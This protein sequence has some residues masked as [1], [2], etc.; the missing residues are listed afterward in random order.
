MIHKTNKFLIFFLCVLFSAICVQNL[1]WADTGGTKASEYY[2][3]HSQDLEQQMQ[4]QT[5]LGEG[6]S[7]AAGTNDLN[8]AINDIKN[9]DGFWNTTGNILKG[10][11]Y[12]LK[13][14]VSSVV[15]ISETVY[16]YT[17]PYTGKTTKYMKTEWGSTV[18][19]EGNM[20]GCTPLPIAVLEASGCTL[21]PLFAVLYD[22]AQ[23]MTEL[24]FDKLAQPMAKVLLIGFAIYI[25]LKVLS[26]VSSFTRKDGPKFVNELLI[27]SFKIFVVFILLLNK[28]QIYKYFVLPILGA[29]LEFGTAI[30]S[31]G[32][33]CSG[34]V[35]VA[36]DTYLL[37]TALFAKLICFIEAIQKEVGIIQAIGSA[38][39][40]VAR[41]QAAS[42]F[43]GFWDMN[44]FFQG[45]VL[46][47]FALM[48]SLAFAFYLIDAT[49][50]LGIVGA[51]MP[52]LI[53]CWPF[54]ITNQ[55]TKAGISIFLAC[56]FTYAFLGIVVSINTQLIAQSFNAAP[57]GAAGG[58]GSAGSGMSS[59]IDALSGD[60]IDEVKRLTDVG[61]GGFLIMICCCVFG[62]KLCS[63]TSDL[64]QKVSGGSIGFAIGAGIGGMAVNAATSAADR[65]TKP[66]RRAIGNKVNEGVSK[67]GNTV[68]QKLGFGKY[69]G[70]TGGKSVGGSQSKLD[71]APSGS[72][73][74]S[75]GGNNTPTVNGES[76]Q[77]SNKNHSNPTQ[78]A[79]LENDLRQNRNNSSHS[80]GNSGGNGG[81][82]GSGAGGG[83]DGGGNNGG[84]GGG[85]GATGNNGSTGSQ[86]Q[87][88]SS[89]PTGAGGDNGGANDSAWKDASKDYIRPQYDKS[90]NMTGNQR[91]ASDG[92]LRSSTS[93]D[94][95]GN[96]HIKNYD[97]SG[98]LTGEQHRN[99]D[100]SGS[101]WQRNGNSYSEWSNDGKGNERVKEYYKDVLLHDR[102]TKDGKETDLAQNLKP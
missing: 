31:S 56:V 38:L 16:T 48:L 29:G 66:A 10:G 86:T 85:A 2:Q 17:D 42:T 100:G 37:S 23:E 73:N 92:R 20:E 64:A 58:G 83:A 22:A 47:A 102:V 76:G 44:M 13:S 36:N 12:A 49:I 99:K 55:Y 25:A 19:A 79:N 90:G 15:G 45:L 65:V 53:L 34:S 69:G 51:L 94:K 9:E 62:F 28:D 11:F 93:F 4:Q 35:S 52:F 18:A 101:G 89:G 95:A 82:N 5:D 24:S 84:N 74:S 3:Q 39:M 14:V 26:H 63:K 75:A 41:N 8:N 71:K 27:L 30:L 43:M 46:W 72:G 40:C 32:A 6:T 77:S 54:K 78:G 80:S 88:N 1:A 81:D 7:Q 87:T 60:N 97:P 68:A 21:C 98:K 61:L 96:E 91:F 50:A 70:K 59:L 67:A 33:Q 57:S